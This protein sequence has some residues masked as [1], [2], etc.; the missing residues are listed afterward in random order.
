MVEGRWG[1][2]ARLPGVGQADSE[3]RSSGPGEAG[4]EAPQDSTRDPFRRQVRGPLVLRSLRAFTEVLLKW[5]EVLA[6][7]PESPGSRR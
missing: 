4:Q 7:S 3:G 6:L 2:G 5:S 1:G